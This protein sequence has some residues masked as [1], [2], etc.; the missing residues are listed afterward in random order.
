MPCLTR[1]DHVKRLSDAYNLAI[2]EAT[3]AARRL[4]T[5]RT[6]AAT[7]ATVHECVVAAAERSQ[8]QVHGKLAAVVSEALQAVFP[9]PYSFVLKFERSR[10]KTSATL[11]FE[12][13]GQ[14]FDPTT[15][16]GGGVLDVAS[17]AL[18]VACICIHRPARR[19]LLILDETFKYLSQDLR[20]R[21]AGLLETLANE[22]GFQFVLISHSPELEIGNVIKIEKRN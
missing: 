3:H 9:D 14:E 10:G 17:F 6:S 11:V 22:L 12:R 1:L 8:R 5:A 15:A 18:R 2:Q 16:S 20:H 21:V 4:E 7:A 19:K 13:G